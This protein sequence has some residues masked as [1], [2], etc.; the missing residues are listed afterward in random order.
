MGE[1]EQPSDIDSDGGDEDFGRTGFGVIPAVAIDANRQTAAVGRILRER[2][3][4]DRLSALGRVASFDHEVYKK[5]S[6]AYLDSP[7]PGRAWAPA[8]P[9]EGVRQIASL[10]PSYQSIDQGDSAVLSVAGEP[11]MPVTFTSLDAGEFQN[12]LSTITVETNEQGIAR[13]TYWATPGVIYEVRILAASPLM[14]GQSR[15]TVQVQPPN[16]GE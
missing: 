11:G 1:S 15:W 10:S 7:E 5:D 9:G 16:E 8:Q 2:K 12:K 14:A 6:R 4:L 13:A 3:D